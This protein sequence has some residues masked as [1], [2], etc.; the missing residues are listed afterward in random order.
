M[1]MRYYKKWLDDEARY[2][3]E[4]RLSASSDEEFMIEITAEEY[5]YETSKQWEAYLA[6][7]PAQEL[8]KELT[9]EELLEI[10]ADLEKENAALLFQML[11]GEEYSDV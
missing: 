4:E 7:L 1:G 9:Y 10:N 6:S 2:Q 5:E 8:S 11:T 3:Y